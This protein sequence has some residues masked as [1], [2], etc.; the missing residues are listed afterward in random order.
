MIHLSLSRKLVKWDK[1]MGEQGYLH[2]WY[3]TELHVGELYVE[4]KVLTKN[5]YYNT[6]WGSILAK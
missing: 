2:Y 4:I 3:I 1:I 6:V 5:K